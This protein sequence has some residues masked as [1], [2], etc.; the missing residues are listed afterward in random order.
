MLGVGLSLG[1]WRQTT[2]GLVSVKAPAPHPTAPSMAGSGSVLVGV[3]G[4][5]PHLVY[6]LPQHGVFPPLCP[7]ESH[8]TLLTF[9]G[10]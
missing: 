2:D 3:S 8:P 1:T 9:V 7:C 10:S 4:S 6:L 5:S